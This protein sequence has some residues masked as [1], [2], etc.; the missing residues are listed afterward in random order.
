MNCMT[1]LLEDLFQVNHCRFNL[2]VSKGS[3]DVVIN[4]N[5]MYAQKS[6]ESLVC[7]GFKV[8][9]SYPIHFESAIN[10][11]ALTVIFLEVPE[12][13]DAT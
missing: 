9:L 2:L 5:L 3:H 6:P 11:N 4:M 8:F 1:F 7:I 12:A 13:E 10:A